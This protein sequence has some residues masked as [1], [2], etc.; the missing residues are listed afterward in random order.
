MNIYQKIDLIAERLE[1]YRLHNPNSA[2]ISYGGGRDS[3]LLLHIVRNVLRYSNSQFPAVYAKTYN[4]FHD[5]RR[6]VEEQ[7]ITILDNGRRV[8]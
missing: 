7:D 8:F 4:E 2:K 3:H 6:R 1:A 5:I